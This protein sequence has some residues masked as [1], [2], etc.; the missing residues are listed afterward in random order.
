LGLISAAILPHGTGLLPGRGESGNGFRAARTAAL[1]VCADLAESRPELLV[2]AWPHGLRPE[3]FSAA[4]TAESAGG[5][6]GDLEVEVTLDRDFA[7]RWAAA[8]REQGWAVY[9][10]GIGTDQGPLA[11]LELDWGA[12]V[13]LYLLSEVLKP[14]PRVVLVAPRRDGALRELI[15][16]GRVLA[17]VSREQR[18]ALIASADQAHAH[19]QDGPYGFH[20]AAAWYDSAVERLVRDGKLSS[21]ADLDLER[22]HLARPDSLWQMLLLAG[23]IGDIR[24]LRC[25]YTAPSYFGLLSA[26]F[27]RK[28]AS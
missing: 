4:V 2:L 10:V 3:G 21:L 25:H 22:V 1:Q 8:C 13:P 23:A 16:T 15:A 18:V 14:L 20:P 5:R 17:E 7:R 6:Q 11:R 24:P 28:E 27:F 9:G 19:R 26:S 12:F